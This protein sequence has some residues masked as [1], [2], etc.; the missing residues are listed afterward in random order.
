M[1]V[2][3]ATTDALTGTVF[4][5]RRITRYRLTFTDGT[6]EEVGSESGEWIP[7]D[8]AP[9]REAMAAQARTLWAARLTRCAAR[10]GRR[11]AAPVVAPAEDAGSVGEMPDW[12]LC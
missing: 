11:V 2:F 9:V 7:A 12:M 3:P 5:E 4:A 8:D 6:T 10:S 1:I